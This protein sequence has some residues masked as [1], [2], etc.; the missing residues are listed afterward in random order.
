MRLIENKKLHLTYII[1]DALEAGVELLGF[2]VKSLRKKQ[3]SLEG[4]RVIVRGGEAFL[5]G[6]YIP[7]Y[8]PSNTPKEYDPYRTRRLLVKKVDAHKLVQAENSKNLTIVPNSLY[9]KKNLLKCEVVF[10][11]K[12]NAHD[13]R[14]TIKKEIARRELRDN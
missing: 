12:K 14:E 4:A 1:E 6:V 11:K 13:K 8:Q 5:V 7:P 9:L 10:C 2:E 3:G